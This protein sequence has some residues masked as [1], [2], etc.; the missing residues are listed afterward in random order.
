MKKIV[1]ILIASVSL[2]AN[3][4]VELVGR[5]N[6]CTLVIHETGY[7][8]PEGAESA[9]T[10]VKDFYGDVSVSQLPGVVFH[11]KTKDGKKFFAYDANTRYRLEVISAMLNEKWA[12]SY[13]LFSSKGK[14]PA[15][16]QFVCRSLIAK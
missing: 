14:W 11:L 9:S 5:P 10:N 2:N 3:A 6:N 7:E 8:S 16:P 15:K 1:L 4:Q 13:S 12:A